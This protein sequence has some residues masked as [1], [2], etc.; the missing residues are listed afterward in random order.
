MLSRT[1]NTVAKC[2]TD[3]TTKLLMTLLIIAIL[4]TLNT[5]D[6]TYKKKYL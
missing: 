4:K 2:T 3:T 5:G 1:T 6:I